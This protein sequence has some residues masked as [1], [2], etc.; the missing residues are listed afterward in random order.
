MSNDYDNP[1]WLAASL[2]AIPILLAVLLVWWF[3]PHSN[4]PAGTD[5]KPNEPPVTESNLFARNR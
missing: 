4:E 2:T 5:V 3:P 1:R